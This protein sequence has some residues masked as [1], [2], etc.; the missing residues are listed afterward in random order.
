MRTFGVVSFLAISRSWESRYRE[1]AQG[2]GDSGHVLAI[3]AGPPPPPLRLSQPAG[4]CHNPDESQQSPP[5]F[6]CLMKRCFPSPPSHSSLFEFL[7]RARRITEAD[8]REERG[9]RRS[10]DRFSALADLK[11]NLHVHRSGSALTIQSRR[12]TDSC[13]LLSP[14]SRTG[15]GTHDERGT[16]LSGGFGPCAHRTPI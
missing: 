10:G 7:S 3:S 8:Q 12:S 2:V 9:H 15:V 14:P 11:G 5:F 4:G 16:A 6:C 13:F 1:Y